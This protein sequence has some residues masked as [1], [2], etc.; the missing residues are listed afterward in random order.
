MKSAYDYSPSLPGG[1][2]RT[3][4]VAR[5]LDEDLREADHV[6]VVEELLGEVHHAVRRVLLR[7]GRCG[8]GE[9]DHRVHGDVLAGHAATRFHLCAT[10]VTDRLY[11]VKGSRRTQAWTHS[12]VESLM[13]CDT[14]FARGAAWTS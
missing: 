3:H 7:A 2:G 5:L 8:L 4:R 6:G 13:S 11:G 12:W 14:R 10:Y 9:R 1:A